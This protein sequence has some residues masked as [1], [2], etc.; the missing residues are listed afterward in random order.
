MSGSSARTSSGVEVQGSSVTRAPCSRNWRTIESLIPVSMPEGIGGN[1][2][3]AATPGGGDAGQ[4]RFARDALD[5][6]GVSHIVLLEGVND[7]GAGA[8]ADQLTD[9][10]T[11]L[12]AQAHDRCI[13][14]IGATITPFQNS[15]Y[16]TPEH[17]QIREAVNAWI[18]TSGVFDGVVD[19]DQALRDPANP[20]QLDPRYH[21]V[22]DLHPNDEGYRVM[23]DAVDPAL[24]KPWK[25][26][27]H[28]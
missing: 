15:V 24:L 6:P 25:G 5:Q 17:E 2:L 1:Q 20:L 8:T 28:G 9:A 27:G 19:F 11:R 23:A 4:V 26:C 3:L 13:A 22:G 14:I 18:R 10:M 7:I 12:V 21:T 16:D